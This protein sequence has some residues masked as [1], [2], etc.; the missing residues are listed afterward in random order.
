MTRGAI[1]QANAPALVTIVARRAQRGV[2]EAPVGRQK[3]ILKSDERF[4]N[5]RA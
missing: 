2:G 1:L 4:L 5:V 3:N